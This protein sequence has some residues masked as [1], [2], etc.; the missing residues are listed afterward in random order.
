MATVHRPVIFLND[1]QE[2]FKKS[3]MPS[4]ASKANEISFS[5]EGTTVSNSLK[6]GQ[7]LAGMA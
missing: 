7:A 2:V 5:I 6:T 3:E 1:D 4:E